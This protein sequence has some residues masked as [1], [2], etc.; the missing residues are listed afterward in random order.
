[1]SFIDTEVIDIHQIKITNHFNNLGIDNIR[2]EIIAGLT[3]KQKYISSKY[4]YD[5]KGSELF[6]D[7]TLLP[8]YYPTRTEKKILT[9]IAPALMHKL[10]HIDIVELGSGDCSKISILLNS[11]PNENLNTI[12]YIPVDVSKSAIIESAQNL[13][14]AFPNLSVKGLVAD[15]INQLELIPATKKRMICLLGSTLGNFTETITN[16]FLRNLSSN[17]NRGDSFL[18]GIDLVKPANILH[19]AYN[20]SQDVTADF[21]KN[22]LNVIND[23]I[24]SDFNINDFDH[25]AFFNQKKSRIEMHLIAN[26]NLTINSPY[27]KIKIKKGENI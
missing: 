14:K 10:R 2:N 4:F 22:I 5:E 8:E 17:M 18:L 26:K 3:S 11:I 13:I 15:F 20:D 27:S 16:D 19:D 21:N 1:M 23:I 12:K 25:E 6:E 7:I 24:D 9:K